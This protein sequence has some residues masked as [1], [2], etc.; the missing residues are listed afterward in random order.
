MPITANLSNVLNPE[1]IDQTVS[2]KSTAFRQTTITVN[3]VEY[4]RGS[5][6]AKI[7]KT[8]Q[9]LFADGSQS[10]NSSLQSI[11]FFEALGAVVSKDQGKD[12]SL[13]SD[14][15]NNT[16]INNPN[17]DSSSA[18]S[19]RI[20]GNAGLSVSKSFT[21]SDDPIFE[22]SADTT[23]SKDKLTERLNQSKLETGTKL[24]S[25]ASD[26]ATL[27]SSS[28]SSLKQFTDIGTTSAI[29]GTTSAT[30]TQTVTSQ[31]AIATQTVVRSY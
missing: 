12:Y 19:V 17:I 18:L 5:S 23:E 24:L 20:G 4:E 16:K 27:N 25:T 28:S 8:S 11:L 26:I 1:S 14:Q 31:M 30:T 6:E 29:A 10:D 9:K 2:L 22:T 15:T 7:A 21:F 13:V 3:G